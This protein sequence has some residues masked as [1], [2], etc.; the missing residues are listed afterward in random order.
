MQANFC[1]S[2]S[3]IS[4]PKQVTWS[5]SVSVGWESI[6][7]SNGDVRQG[8][9]AKAGLYNPIAKNWKQ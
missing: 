5:S 4:Q 3:L 8:Y 2:C 7:D 6:L 9:L 1:T